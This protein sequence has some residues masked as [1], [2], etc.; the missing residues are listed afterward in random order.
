M[1]KADCDDSKQSDHKKKIKQENFP[2]ISAFG[3]TKVY[4]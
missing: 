3:K 2:K 4:L 1:E